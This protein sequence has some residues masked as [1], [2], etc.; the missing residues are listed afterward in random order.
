MKAKGKKGKKGPEMADVRPADLRK[1]R[2]MSMDMDMDSPYM[3]PA[4]LQGSRESFHS[5]SRS[6][7][8]SNDPY[9][10]VP[11]ASGGDPYR[12][13]LRNENS[14]I[15][16]GSSNA[17]DRANL[18]KNAQRNPSSL[19]PR[20]TSLKSES[21][22]SEPISLGSPH[23][24]MPPH[25]QLPETAHSPDTE[26]TRKPVPQPSNALGLAPGAGLDTRDSYF[27]NKA[28]EMRSSTNYLGN[29]IHSRDASAEV[30]QPS[31]SLTKRLPTPPQPPSQTSSPI[32]PLGPVQS[33]PLPRPPVPP[34][35]VEPTVPK[36][37]SPPPVTGLP[38]RPGVGLPTSP[39]AGLPTTP[40]PP[41]LQ[42]AHSPVHIPNATVQ[43]GNTASYASETSDYGDSFRVTP[44]SPPRIQVYEETQRRLSFDGPMP[45]MQQPQP[46]GLGVQGLGQENKRLSMSIRPLPAEDPTDNPEQRANRIRS[47]YKEYFD[48]RKAD[49]MPAA[50]ANYVDYYEDYGQEYTDGAIFDP[51]T[52]NFVFAHAQAPYAEPVTRRAMTPPPRAPPRF[53]GPPGRGHGYSGSSGFL[54]PAGHRSGS[55]MSARSAPVRKNLPPPQP[56]K[57]VPTPHMLKDDAA[58][59]SAADF[60]P[61]PTYRERQNGR[62][63]DSPMGVARPY[64]PSVSPHVPLASA[65]NELSA[66][67][68]P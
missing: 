39:A 4:A 12:S 53:R 9:R 59:F 18:L 26:F 47:F 8:D 10:Q 57:S 28:K 65:F 60:A 55:P 31:G 16:S 50:P 43:P 67:P 15:Y 6:I 61:P 5:L 25:I 2:G 3:L 30:K 58:I 42:S 63:P 21:L 33:S 22:R 37:P 11:Y 32:Q 48:D 56:L 62:R 49:P 36:R 40:R 7:K 66:V 27:D 14:S 17:T 45:V 1:G 64:S 23:P 54:S 38:A 51:S 24:P 13:R 29:F 41:R 52:G 20:G 46:Q 35:I 44:P 34:V 68:S 19:P